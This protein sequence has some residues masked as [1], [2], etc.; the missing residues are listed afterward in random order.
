MMDFMGVFRVEPFCREPCEGRYC[1]H[2]RVVGGERFC[3]V[4]PNIDCSEAPKVYI[5]RVCGAY[6][7]DRRD[8]LPHFAWHYARREVK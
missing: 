8:L 5:C 6:L 7:L 4:N 3:R 2:L 1:R